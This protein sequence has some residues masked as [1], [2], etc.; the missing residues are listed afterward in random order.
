MAKQKNQQDA[1]VRN[2]RA[3]LSRDRVI[4]LRLTNTVNRLR[5]LEGRVRRLERGGLR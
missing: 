1:T 4:G 2:A 3:S 5:K